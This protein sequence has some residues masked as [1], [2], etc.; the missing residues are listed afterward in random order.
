M[1]ENKSKFSINEL[2]K[3]I[4]NGDM[5]LLVIAGLVMVVPII[6]ILILTG[7]PKGG[8]KI[9][10]EKMKSMVHRKNVFNFGTADKNGKSSIPSAMRAGASSSG[11]SSGW[12]SERTPEQVV[13]DEIET[14]MKAVERSM[15]NVEAPSNLAGDEKLM[16]EAEHNYYLC[17]ANG[18]IE[19]RDFAKAEQCIKQALED[20]KGNDFLTAYAYA[21]LCAL[22]E[23]SGDQ[24]K[25]EEAY[26]RYIEAVCKLPEELGG[27]NMKSIVRDAYQSMQ[28]LAKQADQ[29][30]I[31]EALSSNP[32][33]RDSNVGNV[34]FTK[35]YQNFPIKYK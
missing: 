30:K 22:Y 16:Y 9:S 31:A 35:V 10:Q 24:K 21:S 7:G 27:G 20:A 2:V 14:A 4:E 12:F 18:A 25:L 29:G 34:D 8:K 13:N 6:A 23:A 33:A 11:G 1:S 3:K 26:K 28:A 32:I 15:A 17:E 5:S 19:N